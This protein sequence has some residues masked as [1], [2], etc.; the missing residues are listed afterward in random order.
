ML[1]PKIGDNSIGVQ[2]GRDVVIGL[3]Y[4]DVKEIAYDLFK[5]N[6]PSLVNSAAEQAKRNVDEYV[7]KLEDKLKKEIDRIDLQKFSQPNTQYVL[8]ESIRNFAKKGNKIDVDVLTEALI[9]SLQKDS[10]EMLDIVSEQV[11]ELIPKLTIECHQILTILH[12]LL[13]VKIDRLVDISG[14]ENVTSKLMSFINLE[15]EANQLLL[16]YMESLG[17]LSINQFVGINIYEAIKNQ[18]SEFG[19][20]KTI[21]L[22]TDEVKQKC[23]NL[24]KISEYFNKNQL[25]VVALTPSGMLIALINLKKILGPIDYKIWIK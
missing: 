23:P 10:T 24:S 4:S 5:Q 22:F 12:Y 14:S 20:D 15:K 8:N 17:L 9:A 21:E 7:A 19:K 16:R 3:T 13:Y 6:F 11:L 25:G 1:S 2:A 18:Y